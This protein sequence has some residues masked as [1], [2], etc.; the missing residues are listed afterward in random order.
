MLTDLTAT[1]LTAELECA[2]KDRLGLLKEVHVLRSKLKPMDRKVI[3]LREVLGL[4]TDIESDG[5]GLVENILSDLKSNSAAR[6]P[7]V[8]ANSMVT[9]GYVWRGRSSLSTAV[10]QTLVHLV[11]KK[12]DMVIRTSRGMYRLN[13]VTC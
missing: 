8:I 5:Y 2:E 4:S 7:K 6:P 1:E 11:D 9:S 12:P 13:P 10:G 3:A